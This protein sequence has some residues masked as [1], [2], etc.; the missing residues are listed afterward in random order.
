M[1]IKTIL[2]HLADDEHHRPRLE[3]A[4]DLARKYKAHLVALFI[5]SPVGMP[6]QITGRGAAAGYLSAAVET[7]RESAKALKEECESYCAKHSI[8]YD[9][10]VEDGDHL[11]LLTY[12]AHVA[13]LAVVSQSER[14]SLEDRFRLHL[15]EALTMATGCPVLVLPQKEKIGPFGKRILVAWKGYREAVRA[16]R[17]SLDFMKSAEQVTVLAVGQT[18][19]ATASEDEAVAYLKRHGI[20]AEPRSVPIEHENVGETLLQEAGELGC[21]LL[22]MGAFGHSRI[23][24]IILGSVTR[25]VFE[26]TTIPV[27]MAH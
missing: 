2:V 14:Q 13:D 4:A 23:R 11:D 6:A 16:V 8:S 7:A 25:H 17:G 24:E 21:D 15:A 5:T 26:A 10:V 3:V 19:G 9:W 22:I 20:E 1:S 12:H 27:I 18:P